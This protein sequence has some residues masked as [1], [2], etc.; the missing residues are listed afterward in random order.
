MKRSILSTLLIGSAIA[1]M[2]GNRQKGNRFFGEMMDGNQPH[3]LKRLLINMGI[4]RIAS[5][6]YGRSLIR[7]FA[8]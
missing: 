1:L 5:M 7:R 2:W 3:W 8:R 6:A 4:V